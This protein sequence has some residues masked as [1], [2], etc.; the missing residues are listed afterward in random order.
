MVVT[1]PVQSWCA[2]AAR[3]GPFEQYIN[4]AQRFRDVGAKAGADVLTPA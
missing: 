2:D 1:L 4:S 3:C